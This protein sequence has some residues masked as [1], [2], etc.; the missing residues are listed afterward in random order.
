MKRKLL[1]S[2]WIIAWKELLQVKRDR[3]TLALL[4]GVPLLQILLFG[5]A[6]NL[7][8]KALPTAVVSM[9]KSATEQS[10]IEALESTGYFK[11]VLRTPDKPTAEKWM[12]ES[13]TQFTLVLHDN[14]IDAV[15]K[16]KMTLIVDASDP[17]ASTTAI[18][19]LASL[20]EASKNNAHPK[21]SLQIERRF[22]PEAISALYIVPGL[23]GVI[24]T[25]TLTLLAALSIVREVER[26]TWEGLISS[27]IPPMAVL[28]GKILPYLVLG[29]IQSIL[30]LLLARVLFEVPWLGS[31][32]GLVVAAVIFMLANL[33]LGM[34]ISMLAKSQ[35]QAMQMGIFFYLPSILLSGFMFPFYGMPKWAQLIGELLPLTHFLRVIRGVLLK[36]AGDQIA[37]TLV[38]PMGLFALVTLTISILLYRRTLD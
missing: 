23:L 7:H 24:L 4:I 12:L 9:E 2:V 6:I 8:P 21:V 17:I 37:L 18:N 26:G 14:D 27:P 3:L 19:T 5:Y 38:W 35:M 20:F 10:I 29:L 15:S 32:S 34:V 13:R 25:L 11:V 16:Q 36:G 30:I 1:K 28:A 33:G 22:N 31:V